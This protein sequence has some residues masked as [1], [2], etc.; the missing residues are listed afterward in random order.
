MSY[1]K[2]LQINL[3]E[4]QIVKV[5]RNDWD[6]GEMDIE[7]IIVNKKYKLPLTGT[8]IEFNPVND[9]KNILE[10]YLTEPNEEKLKVATCFYV[11]EKWICKSDQSNK[12]NV[13][14]N[15]LQSTIGVIVAD[16]LI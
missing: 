8:I 15:L 9:D 13:S 2:Y 12:D 4:N 11:D 10:V 3:L 6:I 16:G 1:Y 5:N 14:Q 7:E